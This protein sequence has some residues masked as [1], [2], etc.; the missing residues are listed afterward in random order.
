MNTKDNAVC[1]RNSAGPIRWMPTIARPTLPRELHLES[2][3]LQSLDYVRGMCLNCVEGAA[4][5]TQTGDPQDHLLRA[6]DALN[7]DRPGRV[8]I[9]ARSICRLTI[10]R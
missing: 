3:Q 10:V 2:G 7:V 1:F 9:E 5:V 4:W 8:V 6:G